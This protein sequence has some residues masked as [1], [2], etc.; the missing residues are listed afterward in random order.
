MEEVREKNLE[1]IESEIS[2]N[3]SYYSPLKVLLCQRCETGL[4]DHMLEEH[5]RSKHNEYPVTLRREIIYRIRETHQL[6]ED[7]KKVKWPPNP[8]Q[9]IPGFKWYNGEQ[10]LYQS[11][12]VDKCGYIAID[13]KKMQ[14]HIKN[15]HTNHP[16]AE[17]IHVTCQRLGRSGIRQKYFAVVLV[18]EDRSENENRKLEREL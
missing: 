2:S 14:Q 7:P 15:D 13:K 17:T 9:Q 12:G 4:T 5:F 16:Q 8:L 1:D 10:C 3:F 11:S 18:E 6:A